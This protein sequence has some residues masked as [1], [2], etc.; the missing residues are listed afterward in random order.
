MKIRHPLYLEKKLYS[1][2]KYLP[3]EGQLELTYRCQ[4]DCVHCYCQGLDERRKELST[5]A[6][7][8]ILDQIQK[9]G[10][11]RLSFTGGDSLLRE[12]FLEIYSYAKRKGFLISVLTNGYSLNSRILKYFVKSPPYSVEITVNGITARTFERITRKNGSFTRVMKNIRALKEN[13]IRCYIKTNLLTLNA[14]EIAKIKQW[15]DG[16]LGVSR[17][18]A[19]Y[20]SFDPIIFPKLNGDLAPCSYRLSPDDMAKIFRRDRDLFREYK[21]FLLC[22]FPKLE[23]PREYLYHCSSWR[24]QFIINPCGKLKFCLFT[25]KFSVDLKKTSFEEGFYKVFPLLRKEKFKTQSKCQ[26]CS[27]R[28]ICNWCPVKASL[29]TGNAEAPVAYYC[30]LAEHTFMQDKL[31]KNEKRALC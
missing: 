21:E 22:E 14:H 17:A 16:F 23:R 7:K 9:A 27:L 28:A 13:N 26:A 12:D 11:F 30:A 6:W 2:S 4:F 1:K 10:C 15:V 19:Y 29:E 18:N 20:F 24:N 8:K 25:E 3:L 31:I 5:S